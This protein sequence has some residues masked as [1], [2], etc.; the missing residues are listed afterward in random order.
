MEEDAFIDATRQIGSDLPEEELKNLWTSANRE[1]VP[2]TDE[3]VLEFIDA[4]YEPG[5][6]S[7][8]QLL[9]NYATRNSVPASKNASVPFSNFMKTA[10]NS[11]S[12]TN[13]LTVRALRVTQDK[14][15][16]V[17][18]FF[19][20]AADLLQIAE[21]SRVKRNKDGDLLGYQRKQV[22]T[23]IDEITKYVDSNEVVFPNAIILALG[24]QVKFKKGR[25]PQIGD[26]GCQGGAL[27]I[28]YDPNEPKVAWV[29]D[30]QQ[31]TLALSKAKNK[32]YSSPLP[33][34]YLMTSKSTVLNSLVN[35]VR[36]LPKGLI[37]ELLPEINVTLP[38]SLSR[39]RIPSFLCE[40]LNKDPQSPLHG[41]I[42][43]H[44]TNSRENKKAVI[45]DSSMIEVIRNSLTKV[46]GC[47]YPYRNV[48]TG[49]IDAEPVFEL[50][51][52]YWD[53][54]RKAFP[55]AWGISASKSRLMHGVG[56]KSMGVLMDRVGSFLRR[57]PIFAIRLL[58]PCSVS[59][60]IATGRKTVG[61]LSEVCVARICKTL[62]PPSTYWPTYSFG[63]MPGWKTSEV[64]LC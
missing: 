59:S 29:V 50:L 13:S 38:P 8:T 63:H 24:S 15:I 54:V 5:V 7:A 33:L 19:L 39:N 16:P 34:L 60:R 52:V 44:T 61:N 43:R 12:S 1:T 30:G 35:K 53:E 27:E 20:T 6:S 32:D 9:P 64:F 42:N 10:T 36:P 45:A 11:R 2:M 47:F 31:R 17:Y 23:H 57:I 4:C 28:P 49:Q 41:L 25:G 40:L 56:I 21:I 37:N 55:D 62:H 58:L 18:T 3:E 26:P 22:S 14:K 48:A 46:H 51:K